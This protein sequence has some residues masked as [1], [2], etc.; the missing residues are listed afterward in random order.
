M[1]SQPEDHPDLRSIGDALQRRL[2]RILETEQEAAATL[3]RRT[4]I[5]RDR[6]LDAEDGLETIRVI[7]RCGVA[8][9]GVLE[10]VCPDH[11]ELRSARRTALVMIDQIAVVELP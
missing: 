7:T 11:L 8:A 4:T 5:L 6:L 1:T 9:E 2:D 3:A 10:A